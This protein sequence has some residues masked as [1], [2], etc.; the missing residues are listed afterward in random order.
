MYMNG[1]FNSDNPMM[2]L[3][4]N[5][6]NLMFV[7]ILFVFTC[8]PIVTIGPSLCALY[9]V[10]LT[11]VGGEDTEVFKTYFK[12]FKASFWKGLG[13][14]M[15]VLVA[16]G[17]FG[18][19]LYVIY[20]KGELLSGDFSFLQYPVWIMLLLV[21]QIFLYGF[22][23][24]ASFEN[25][26]KKT[27]VNSLLLSIKNFTTTIM[28]VVIWIFCAFIYAN[29]PDMQY[30]LIGFE[31]FFNFALRVYLCSIFLHKA[32]GLKKIRYRKDGSEYE[33]SWEEEDEDSDLESDD[34]DGESEDDYE[35]PESDTEEKESSD[36]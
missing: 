28:L 36:D 6:F 27:I 22:A 33:E 7:N 12:E 34:D 30:M 25:T 13:L 29:V 4:T 16:G 11:I 24:L 35:D 19:E 8:I 21:L 14:W 1:A 20:F 26:L 18:F 23:L 32:F 2:R 5:F 15:I 9:K 17:F 3:L 31:L 10:C